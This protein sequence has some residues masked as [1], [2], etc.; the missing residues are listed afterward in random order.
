MTNQ[1]SR[2]PNQK[3]LDEIAPNASRLKRAY[4]SNLG[5]GLMVAVNLHLL[6]LGIFWVAAYATAESSVPDIGVVIDVGPPVR[7]T[8]PIETPPST[9]TRGAAPTRPANLGIPTPVPDDEADPEATVATEAERLADPGFGAVGD[10]PGSG[11]GTETGIGSTPPQ[12]PVVPD[13]PGPP[14]TPPPVV[15]PPAVPETP[16]VVSFAEKM[17]TLIGGIDRFQAGI[18]YP[19]FER[20]VGTGGRVIVQF[21]VSETGVPSD[22]EVLRSVSPGLDRAAVDAVRQARFTPGIQNGVPVRVRFTLP[23]TFQLR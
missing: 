15:E 17:P 3:I 4:N 1:P 20:Q 18:E 12:P 14:S 10:T 19:A 23:V 22:I 5:R 9:P 16:S 13:P 8:P 2:D 7:V 11:D 6:A 21:V